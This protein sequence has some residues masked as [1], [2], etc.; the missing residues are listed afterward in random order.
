MWLFCCPPQVDC[1][2]RLLQGSW[3]ELLIFNVVYQQTRH[4]Q[5]DELLVVG[6]FYHLAH[7]AF[8]TLICAICILHSPCFAEVV[9]S[10]LNMA[11]HEYERLRM[12][13]LNNYPAYELQSSID[14]TWSYSVLNI[15]LQKYLAALYFR[16]VQVDPANIAS[17]YFTPLCH[18]L[19]IVANVTIVINSF[20]TYPSPFLGAR[21]LSGG[22][23]CLLCT[24]ECASATMLDRTCHLIVPRSRTAIR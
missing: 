1:Q 22:V 9:W 3:S 6:L 23:R 20:V 2:M 16:C 5:F 14:I 19:K 18:F 7:H 12:K 4:Q 24:P 10:F 15:A 8:L 13:T 21:W 17:P 11:Q